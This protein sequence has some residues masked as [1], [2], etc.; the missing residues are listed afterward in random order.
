MTGV[1]MHRLVFFRFDISHLAFSTTT[2]TERGSYFFAKRYI[3]IH[4][5]QELFV[6]PMVYEK[7]K[8]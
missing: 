5:F 2:P 6:S 3:H 1:G 8:A 4:N 7:S